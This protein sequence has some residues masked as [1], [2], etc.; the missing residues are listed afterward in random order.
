MNWLPLTDISQLDEIVKKSQ[1][2]TVA[3]F[4]H[5]TRCSISTM[6]KK[7]LE[8]DWDAEGLPVYFLILRFFDDLVEL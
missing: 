8:R 2:Q 3:I 1:D 4:K 7:T 5:S 6:A